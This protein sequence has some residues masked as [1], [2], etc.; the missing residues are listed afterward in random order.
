MGNTKLSVKGTVVITI[1][2]IA[3]ITLFLS[4]TSIPAGHTGVITTFGKVSS[5][6]MDEGL[7]FKAP[8]QKVTKV[9]NRIVKLEVETESSTKDLQTV[10]TIL[11]VSYR[12]DTNMS[13][14]IIKNIGKDYESVIVTPAVN[15]T[16]KAITAK[17]TAEE[18]ITTRSKVSQELIEGINEKLNAQGISVNDVNIINFSFSDA[19][20]KA[21]EEKQVAEQQLKKA[22]TEKQAKIVEAQA[23]AEA[24]L[25][26]AKAEAEAN[27]MLNNSLTENV[28]KHDTI[29]K[30]NGELPKVSSSDSMITDVS[31][32]LDNQSSK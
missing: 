25:T 6:V 21:V 18:C 28:I 16:L 27:K 7:R 20:N 4:I 30:W 8:W 15:E 13:Y 12:I 1:I 2:I 22:E 17:Y 11:A 29:A 32:I 10:S 26:K 24:T 9:D 31:S 23:V 3:I 14:S 19:Y 5:N